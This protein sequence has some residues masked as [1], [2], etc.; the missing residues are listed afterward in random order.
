MATQASI[1][2]AVTGHS[3]ERRLFGRRAVVRNAWITSN[4]GQRTAC[5]LRDISE[6][7][8]LLEVPVGAIVGSRLTVSLA[9]G[10]A[11]AACEARH[12]SGRTIGVRFLDAVEGARFNSLLVGTQAAMP[13]PATSAAQT[14]PADAGDV[15]RLMQRAP[16]V[17]C[18]PPPPNA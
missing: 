1:Q 6:G 18:L 11:S 8:A 14:T 9:E 4:G 12:R 3:A 2:S 17:I 7:G 5:T 13:K 15:A 16:A 10:S